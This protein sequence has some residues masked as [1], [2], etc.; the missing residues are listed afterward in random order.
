QAER[1]A[2]F[3][4][5]FGRERELARCPPAAHLH[6]VG[7]ALA[8]RRRGMRDVGDLHEQRVDGLVD[9]LQLDVERLDAIAD[10]AH[11]RAQ[12][13]RHA[14][15]VLRELG[16]CSVPEGLEVVGSLDQAASL[17][18]ALD[19]GLDELAA[20]L[21]GERAP[22]RVWL[23][24]DE[25]KIQHGRLRGFGRGG[26]LG[27]DAG[28]RADAIVGVEIDDAHAHRVAALRGDLVGVNADDLALGGDEQDVVPTPDLQHADHGAV[29]ARRLNVDDP[30]AGSALQAV[31]LERRPLAEAAL[32]DRK[33]LR[34]LL[35]DVG[36]DHLVVVLDLDPAH[37]GGAAAHRADFLFREAD[38]HAELRGD[39]HLATAIGSAGR[40]ELVAVLE[41]HR[42][43]AAG[44]RMRIRLQLGLLHLAL[45]G[46]EEDVATGGEIPNRHARGHVLTV[47]ERQ[48][49]HH[50]LALGGSTAFGNLV[51]LEPVGLAE[52]REEQQV[53]VGRGNEQVLDDVL[54]LGLHPGHA[55]APAPL[56]AVGLDV[57]ALDVPRARDGD[58]HLL[59]G[60]QILDGQV[61]GL[62]E[63]LRA[64]GVAVLLFDG[65]Q[66]LLDDSHQLD[67]GSEDALELFDELQGLLV[68]LD[69]LLPL[70]RRQPAE[71]HVEDGL[72]LDLG[73]VQPPHELVAG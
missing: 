5:G 17:G 26:A 19:D 1:F 67:V 72:G 33:D 6:V 60:Q 57:R 13:L 12:I 69:D 65:H 10:P 70:Q 63:D 7:V 25:A 61:G 29:A 55:L 47:P 41:A 44:P 3:L 62:E 4:V 21:V 40:H 42:L 68:L 35:D 30:L 49:V 34:A 58:H 66:L 20:T 43:D 27:F 18:V 39:H 24:A 46:H 37:A 51:Q 71:L 73:E 8:G 45:A 56:A 22:D 64:A 48:E 11:L 53:G 31:L 16:G 38:R 23:L 52:V 15:L 9:G 54:F 14:S 2:D 28:D 50:G 59:V 32:R 36:S